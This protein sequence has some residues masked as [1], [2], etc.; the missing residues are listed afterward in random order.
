MKLTG[1][2]AVF[3]TQRGTFSHPDNLHRTLQNLVDQSNPSTI[4]RR[5]V[6]A[7]EP[8][9]FVTLERRLIIVTKLDGKRAKL[10]AVLRDSE[11]LPNVSPHD[12]RRKMPVEVVSKIL[13]HADV[14]ITLNV[15][16]RV[17]ESEKEA[18]MVDLFPEL[19]LA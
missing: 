8:D 4:R 12:L 19:V 2:T 10:E 1:D 13:G 5:K 16:R 7:A 11:P 18:E 15:Y 6:N 17:L 3:A 14:S 9:A